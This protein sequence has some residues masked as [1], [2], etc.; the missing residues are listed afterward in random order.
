AAHAANASVLSFS[1]QGEVQRI[2]QVRAR[3]SESM[4]KF[5]DPKA[6]SPFDADCAISGTARWADDKNWV[7]DFERD[8]PPGTRC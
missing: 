1:P 3:F 5:G 7:Y 4:V 2:R 6:A 8:L